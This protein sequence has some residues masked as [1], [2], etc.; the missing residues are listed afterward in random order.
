MENMNLTDN[1]PHEVEGRDT[2]T[3]LTEELVAILE[4]INR[5]RPVQFLDVDSDYV[6]NFLRLH[7]NSGDNRVYIELSGR[8]DNL[9]AHEDK[10]F[11]DGRGRPVLPNKEMSK[12]MRS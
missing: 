2:L 7:E 3:C 5:I 11:D 6:Y 8:Y 1:V 12:P 10:P 9:P 4:K